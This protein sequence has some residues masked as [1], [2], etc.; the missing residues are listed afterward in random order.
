MAQRQAELI[1]K[2]AAAIA[3][4][5]MLTVVDLTMTTERACP[6]AARNTATA[7]SSTA[8]AGGFP[9]KIYNSFS[10]ETLFV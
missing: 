7:A 2:E 10:Q 5:D 3:A 6:A 9:F 8:T 4:I 1:A